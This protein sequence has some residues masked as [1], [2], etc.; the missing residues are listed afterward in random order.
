MFRNHPFDQVERLLR[1]ERP[2][3]ADSL[4]R[5]L[6]SRLTPARRV[7]APRIAFAGAMTATMLVALASVGGVS[8]AANAAVSAVKVVKKAV[9]PT[10]EKAAISVSGISSGGDQYR[11]GYG[12]G[13]RNHNH[14]GPPGMR[15]GRGN[16][17]G[18]AAPPLRARSAPG[19]N[20]LLVSTDVTFDEQASLFVSVIDRNDRPVLLTQKSKRGGSAVGAG[21]DGPQTKFIRYALLVP[22]AIPIQLRIPANLLTRGAQYRIRV[23]AFD[24]EG[25]RSVLMVPF[26]A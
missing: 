12:W 26:T 11:P 20:A 19:G 21:V 22:R 23:V 4:V 3:P 2:Q 17:Q 15:R 8:Y 16:Q 7:G 18:E 24:P 1:R 14:T 6:A 10:G 13:D 25:N 5:A 9:V